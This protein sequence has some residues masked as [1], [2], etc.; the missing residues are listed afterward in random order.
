[1]IE[2][3]ILQD[4]GLTEIEA[5][6]YLASLELGTETV[7]KIAKQAQ[8]K[9]PTAYVAL[10][11]L[12]ANG[13]VSKVQKK[14]TTMYAAESPEIIS[15]KFKEK[16]ANFNDLMPFFAAKFNRGPKPKIRYYEGAQTLLDIYTKVLFPSAEIY[17]FGTDVAKIKEKLPQLF[18]YGVTALAKKSVKPMEIVS[19]NPA[20]IEYVKKYAAGRPIKLMPKSLPVFAD[21]AITENKIFIVSLDNLFGVLIESE[22]LAKTFKNFFLL[23]WSAA[24]TVK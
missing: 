22:D 18:N 7:L 23:A 24:T 10:D 1:M 21:V 12:F 5:K 14:G 16:L 13:F 19:Y 8:V 6:I 4:L 11:N 9:R 3:K 2:A 15:N 20:G 17:F